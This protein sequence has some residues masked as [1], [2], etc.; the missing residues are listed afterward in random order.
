MDNIKMYYIIWEISLKSSKIGNEMQVKSWKHPLTAH[1]LHCKFELTYNRP[2]IL[3]Q[4]DI[5]SNKIIKIDPIDL[6]TESSN[7]VASLKQHTGSDRNQIKSF[8]KIIQTN[9]ISINIE[10]ESLMIQ[11]ILLFKLN[12]IKNDSME[13][14]GKNTMFFFHQKMRVKQ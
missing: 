12:K 3:N 1:E 6:A 10:N 5:F 2:Q 13:N 4:K 11:M 7:S 9:L 14:R 8:L